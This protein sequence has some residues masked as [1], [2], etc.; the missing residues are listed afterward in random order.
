MT[1]AA[2]QQASAQ[3]P[4]QPNWTDIERETLESELHRFVRLNWEI[5]TSLAR[6]NSV[7]VP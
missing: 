6:A 3:S 4:R 5:V 7:T 2:A 1:L